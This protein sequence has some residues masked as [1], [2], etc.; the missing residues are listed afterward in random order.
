[1]NLDLRIPLKM[2]TVY[3]MCLFASS[4]PNKGFVNEKA[5]S[6][7]P[8]PLPKILELRSPN[9]TLLYF[10]TYHS[11][12]RKDTLFERINFEFNRLRPSYILH[13]G[14]NNWPIYRSMDSTILISGEPGYIIK[15]AQENNLPYS[16]LEPP[17]LLEFSALNHHFD[18]KDIV[19]MYVCRQ[20]GQ[21]QRLN[22]VALI[23]DVEF[24][25]K[26]SVFLDYLSNQGIA[27]TEEEL[28]F[29]FWKEVFE[30]FFE[31]SLEWR[32]FDP[33]NYYPNFF[34]NC[35]NE[36]SRASDTYR[37]KFMVKK[38]VN[39]LKKYDKVMVLV[40]GGH[41]RQQEEKIKQ[42][43]QKMFH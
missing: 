29:S 30:A 2:V 25:N 26:M 14:D 6:K 18:K 16:N 20:I 7:T 12:N 9:K 42:A 27:L 37:N 41:L 4:C 1:M 36:I 8:L 19:L 33:A 31:E 32:R 23:T 3:S 13:E 10:G 39:S 24:E 21:L 28:N 22:E 34:K 15:K 11:N 17:L 5:M 40:G 38:I 43:F 35:L